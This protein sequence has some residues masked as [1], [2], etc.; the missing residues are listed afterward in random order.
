MNPDGETE[1]TAAPA[2]IPLVDRIN[3]LPADRRVIGDNAKTDS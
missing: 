2:I 3:G 1:A